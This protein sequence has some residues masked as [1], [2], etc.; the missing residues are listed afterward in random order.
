MSLQTHI[1]DLYKPLLALWIAIQ[2]LLHIVVRFFC[3]VVTTSEYRWKI[4]LLCH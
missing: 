4:V 1:A 3:P 2:R